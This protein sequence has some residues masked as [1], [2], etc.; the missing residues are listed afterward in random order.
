MSPVKTPDP[1]DH[2]CDTLETVQEEDDD[3]M[4][5]ATRSAQDASSGVVAHDEP[6]QPWLHDLEVAVDGNVTVLSSTTGDLDG[7]GAAGLYVDD[8]RVLSVLGVSLGDHA[9]VPVGSASSGGRSEFISSARHLGAP[10]PDPT[11]EVHRAR[12]VGRTGLEEVVRVASRAVAITAD[13]VLRLGGDGAPIE[14]VKGG[15]ATGGLADPTLGSSHASWSLARHGVR[16]DIEPAPRELTVADDGS[17]CVVLPLTVAGGGCAEVRVVVT[18]TRTEP[19]LFDA[20]PGSDA[21]AWTRSFAVT[22]ADRRLTRVVETS[23]DDLQH[24]VMRDPES[25]GDIFVAAGTPWYLTLFG[26]DSV[27]T[28]RLALPLGTEL[29]AGTLRA[30]ARRQGT[31]HDERRAEDPGKIP[32]EL[33]RTAYVEGGQGL[34]LPPVYY[35]TVD[36]T[37]LWIC[38]L[39]DAWRWGLAESEVCDLLPNLRAAAT[40]LTDVA[41]GDDGLL[42]YVDA[43]GAGLVNQGWK[44]SGDS[45][46]WQDG[47]VA[48]APIALVEAQAYAVEAARGAAHLLEALG[49]GADADQVGTLRSFADGLSS[50]VRERFWVADRH[51]RHLALAIDGLGGAVDGMGSNM[52]HCLGTGTLTPAEATRVTTTLTGDRMLG[53]H[54]ILTLSTDN[55]GF[56]PLGYHTGSVWTH[57]SAI[58]ALGMAR[59]GHRVEAG[60]V[61]TRLLDAAEAFDYRYPELF[62]DEGVLGRPVP[63]PASCRP[64]AWSAASAIALVSVALGLSVDVPGRTVTVRPPSPGPFGPLS[65]RG[66]RV[67]DAVLSVSVEVG[68]AVTV[69]GL[70]AGFSLLTD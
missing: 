15:S 13:L 52:G 3:V 1:P 22:A 51:G 39:H 21:V 60:V 26:R 53:R 25:P 42:K 58:C 49:R 12:T 7:L 54:G 50:L 20:D 44:D 43:S 29:A 23:L 61:A 27:W 10:G 14:A 4:T 9:L 70:P 33:R 17:V 40:W 41:P 6:R 35:G 5:P 30:L 11:V 18:T 28:A 2:D 67:G 47:R 64:Q 24:L 59:E 57:D 31:V 32:H 68:G 8:E 46:R 19:S 45:I 66:I 36:A 63:Y 69:E 56:N 65:V 62:A 37:A 16:V 48:E 34:E 38:L 55:G